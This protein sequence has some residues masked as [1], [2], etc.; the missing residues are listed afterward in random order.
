LTIKPSEIVGMDGL[1]ACACIAVFG[2]HIQQVI[3]ISHWKVG[4]FEFDRLFENGNTGVCFFFMLS[5]ALL[6]MPFWSKGFPILNSRWIALYSVRRAARILPSYYLCL[7]ALILWKRHWIS[8]SEKL[9]SLLHLF[10]IHNYR[11][12]SFYSIASPF[13][14]VAVQAQFY[15]VFPLILAFLSLVKFKGFAFSREFVLVGLIGCVCLLHSVLMRFGG[16]FLVGLGWDDLVK[17]NPYVFSHSLLAHLPHFVLGIL[18]GRFIVNSGNR[19]V[20][21]TRYW[22]RYDLIVCFSFFLLL[23]VL[24]S[25]LEELTSISHCRYN[26]PVVPILLSIIIV[27]TPRS[28]IFSKVMEATW[29]KLLGMASYGFYLCHFPIINAVSVL[30]AYLRY[31]ISEHW[32]LFSLVCFCTSFLVS[33]MLFFFFERPLLI[34]TRSPEVSLDDKPSR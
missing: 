17:R 13:W 26:F 22:W 8:N 9:D 32:Q 23:A 29:L 16:A 20:N 6:S 18:T 2:V 11:E 28:Y 7:V 34:R 19:I 4:P 30:F 24:G 1:R 33:F 14:T 31:S 5:G 27:A 21:R 12:D 10:L 15:V 3:G 25:S